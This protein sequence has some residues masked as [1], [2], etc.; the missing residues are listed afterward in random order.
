LLGSSLLRAQAV[1]HLTFDDPNNLTADSSGHGHNGQLNGNPSAHVGGVSGGAVSLDGASSIALGSDA[2]SALTGSFSVSLWVRT[3]QTPG[4]DSDNANQGAG[5]LFAPGV[6]G[7][8]ALPVVINGHVAGT[9]DGQGDLHSQSAVN[10]GEWVNVVVTHN[11]DD[12]LTSLFVNGNLEASQQGSTQA[13][14]VH[15]L[16]LL[17]ANPGNG[18]GLN[19]EL[20]DFQLYDHVIPASDVAFLHANPG[21]ALFA[22][23]PEP[24]TLALLACGLALLAGGVRRRFVG[25]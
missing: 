6:N 2:A 19:G 5:L 14:T 10:D 8:D 17:G 9:N 23:I 25:L 7:S 4:N 12:G 21:S 1:V 20:D 22:S 11:A 18:Q 3:T 15:D 24:S 16:L 13:Q